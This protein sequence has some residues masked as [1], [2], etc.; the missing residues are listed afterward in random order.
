MR[1]NY[2]NTL[3]IPTQ[4]TPSDMLIFQHHTALWYAVEEVYIEIAQ[5]FIKAGAKG[6]LKYR[7]SFFFHYRAF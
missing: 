3:A 1:R 5:L 6:G 2:G 4:K 7:P